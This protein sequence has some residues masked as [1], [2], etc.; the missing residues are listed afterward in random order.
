MPNT[1][2]A[3]QCQHVPGPENIADLP[4]I[5]AQVQVIAIADYNSCSVLTSMLQYQQGIID[6]L[7]HWPLAHC[8]D[9]SAHKIQP[10][11]LCL[12]KS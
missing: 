1:H 4:V 10:G 9:Y 3:D 6:H 5:L 11:E 8:S 7:G 2:V 12:I